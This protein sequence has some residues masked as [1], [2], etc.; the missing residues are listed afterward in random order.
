LL[1]TCRKVIAE[2]LSELIDVTGLRRGAP[3]IYLYTL[4]L[5]N[6]FAESARIA[7]L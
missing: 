1:E 2:H 4:L 7:L 5:Q 6:F 3:D